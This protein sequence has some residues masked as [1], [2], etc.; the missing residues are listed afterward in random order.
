M[1]KPILLFAL[2]CFVIVYLTAFADVNSFTTVA[3]EQPA[4]GTVKEDNAGSTI[5]I[6][7]KNDDPDNDNR[8]LTQL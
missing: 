7:T 2:K 3:P 5:T 6:T 1:K 8:Y 4:N